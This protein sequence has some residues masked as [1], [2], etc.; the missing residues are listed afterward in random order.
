MER[1]RPVVGY[2]GLYEVSDEGRVR[3]LDRLLPSERWGGLRKLSG[4][5][6][7]PSDNGQ[8]GHQFVRLWRDKKP[9]R[10]YV[11]HLVLEAFVGP[12]PEGLEALH[13]DDTPTNNRLSNLRWGTRSENLRDS[14]RNGRNHNA[15]KTHCSRGGHPL[16]GD[17]LFEHSDGRRECRT[18]RRESRRRNEQ[19]KKAS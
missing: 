8:T 11:H 7:K 9:C 13:Q 17:N 10:R 19:R 18:C 15:S 14:V 12:R 2:E 1:W 6:L 16:A 4:A 3:S 5:I